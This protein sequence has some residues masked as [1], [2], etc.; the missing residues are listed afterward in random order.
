MDSYKKWK[1]LGH[2]GNL[3][4]AL[5]TAFEDGADYAIEIHADNQY[6]P[7]DIVKANQKL[8]DN[9]DLIIGSRI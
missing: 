4:K 7:K 2:G 3:K 1:N 6:S 5:Q 9:Y 8:F